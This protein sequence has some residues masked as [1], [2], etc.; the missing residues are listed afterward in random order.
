VAGRINSTK[1]A[2]TAI[3]PNYSWAWFNALLFN[4][5]LGRLTMK[6][7]RLVLTVS[8]AA[9]LIGGTTVASEIYKWTDDDGNAHY[10]DRPI[11]GA[12][13]ERLDIVSRNTDNSAIQARQRS[14]AEARAAARQVAAE[15]PKEMSKREVRA[16]QE[17]R[18]QQC[19]IYRDRLE[20]FS[21]SQR[22]FEEG[23][24]GERRYLDE[25]QTLAAHN[26]V[27][28]QINKYCGT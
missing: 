5:L 3:T 15:A 18:Q 4:G 12:N 7:Y 21:R 28:Q 20:R 2:V 1:T 23:E 16:E 14:D 24:D 26:R 9:L 25:V 10:E 6:R 8:V 27:E 11:A 17:K 22:L 13:I 19:Q